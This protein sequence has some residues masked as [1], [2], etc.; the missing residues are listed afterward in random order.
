MVHDSW[1]GFNRRLNAFSNRVKAAN[2]LMGVW[3]KSNHSYGPFEMFPE[4]PE[5]FEK[6]S[7]D[8]GDWCFNM[9][10]FL[11]YNQEI[12]KEVADDIYNRICSVGKNYIDVLKKRIFLEKL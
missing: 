11:K 10:T 6:A 9:A 12:Y 1:I 8:V 7:K 3:R 4:E 2:E 5:E